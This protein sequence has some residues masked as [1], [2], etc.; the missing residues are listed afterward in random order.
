MIELEVNDWLGK[1]IVHNIRPYGS[2]PKLSMG[3]DNSIRIYTDDVELPKLNFQLESKDQ[4]IAMGRWLKSLYKLQ[5]TI[6]EKY[7]HL[8]SYGLRHLNYDEIQEFKKECTR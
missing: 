4:F 2:G 7:D 3:I 5:I 8:K 1:K 6:V